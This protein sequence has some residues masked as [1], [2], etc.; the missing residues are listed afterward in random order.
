MW[1]EEPVMARIEA[2][3]QNQQA[4]LDRLSAL[5]G[6]QTRAAAARSS[7]SISPRPTAAISPPWRRT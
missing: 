3:G 1:R 7:R 6:A 4:L 2:L 5:P